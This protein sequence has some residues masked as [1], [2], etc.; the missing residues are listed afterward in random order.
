MR[1]RKTGQIYLTT[2]KRV[3]SPCNEDSSSTPPL[4]RWI[5]EWL[6]T[7]H[8]S[9]SWRQTRLRLPTARHLLTLTY[10]LQSAKWCSS[11][12]GWTTY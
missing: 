12:N 5:S 11:N 4:P 8:L 9:H 1:H 3:D 6:S 7:S 10:K 2:T